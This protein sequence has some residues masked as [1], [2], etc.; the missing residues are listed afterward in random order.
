MTAVKAKFHC[1][2]YDP[3]PSLQPLPR[4]LFLNLHRNVTHDNIMAYVDHGKQVKDKFHYAIL[5]ADRS[6]AG[7]RQVRLVADLQRAGILPMI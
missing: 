2:R 7:R 1:D 3:T 5:V 4:Y 6:E